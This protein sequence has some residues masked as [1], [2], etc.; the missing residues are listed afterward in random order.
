MTWR[1]R[2]T[3]LF[4]LLV[5]A[6]GAMIAPSPLFAQLLP[7][8]P[9]DRRAAE[10]TEREKKTY[11]GRET[12]I[13][14]SL[15]VQE[16]YDSNVYFI[17][18]QNL[19][20]YVTSIGPQLRVVHRGPLIDGTISGGANGEVY[21]K[22]PGLNY[23]GTNALVN[24]NFDRALSELVKGAGLEI[25]DTFYYTPQPPAFATSGTSQIPESF[26][27]GI[28]AQRRNALT[29]QATANGSYEVT[30]LLRLRAIY[31][32]QRIRFGGA[33]FTPPPGSVGPGTPA[34]PANFIN[35][36]FQTVTTG[37]EYKVTPLDVVSLYYQHQIGSFNQAGAESGFSTN[38][39]LL[40]WTRKLTSTFTASIQG[41]ALVFSGTNNLQYQGT[42]SLTY[43]SRDLDVTLSYSRAISPSFFTAGVP[44]LSQIVG[45]TV[46]Y[47][48]TEKLTAG[49]FASYA[50]NESIP[51]SS[52]LKFESVAV[53]PSVDYKFN[54]IF[55]GSLSYTRS[56]F[57]Q[58]FSGSSFYFARNMVTMRLTA[59]WQ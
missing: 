41:G 23:I 3:S 8:Y 33:T 4:L 17:P 48:F 19:E 46:R 54:R 20:D 9:P 53:T 24:V 52:V 56:D 43:L 5:V 27:R 45:A 16:R 57:N 13:I 50:L 28:Q 38:G 44:L 49:V 1:A 7:P 39:A 36:T 15:Y 47:R 40:G 55:S 21:V 12:N 58:E 18:G 42:A 30:P 25:S 11:P 10:E 2:D 37:P 31:L 59:E 26:T 34:T 22:N 32:D 51:D 29:N 6:F 35:T 14:P